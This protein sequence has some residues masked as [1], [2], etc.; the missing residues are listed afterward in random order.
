MSVEAAIA[1]F[2]KDAGMTR[3]GEPEGIAELMAFLLSPRCSL[4]GGHHAAHGWR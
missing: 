1:K 4:D 2:P 3:D